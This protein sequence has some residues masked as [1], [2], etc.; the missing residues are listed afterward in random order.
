MD[1]DDL[2]KSDVCDIV[3]DLVSD[4]LYYSC[5][6][7]EDREVGDIQQAINTGVITLE[8]I[9]AA[10]VGEIALNTNKH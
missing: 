9:G 4:F 1:S 5:K 8:E 3:T 10:F 7:N 2:S 6:N